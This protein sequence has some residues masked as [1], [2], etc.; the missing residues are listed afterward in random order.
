[1]N[2]HQGRTSWRHRGHN[3]RAELRLFGTMYRCDLPNMTGLVHT[4]LEGLVR[5]IDLYIERQDNAPT[6]TDHLHLV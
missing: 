5:Q 3:I 6:G 1:M 4:D 2:N